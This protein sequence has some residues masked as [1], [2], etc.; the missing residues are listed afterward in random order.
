[1]EYTI[2]VIEPTVAQVHFKTNKED[3]D[4]A[5]EKAYK[6]AA[7]KLKLPG[8]RVGKAPIDLVK[9]QLG[10]SV[11]EDAI[12][13]LLIDTYNSVLEQLKPKPISLP[14]FNIVNLDKSNGV[15]FT[16]EYEFLPEIHLTKYKK[17]KAKMYELEED[18]TLIDEIL[19]TLASRNPIYLPKEFENESKNVIEEGDLVLIHLKIF[20]EN[21]NK[22]LYEKE[23]YYV[24]LSGTNSLFPEIKNHLLGKK[25]NDEFEFK[26]KMGQSKEFKKASN[27]VVHIKGKILEIKYKAIP[28]IDDEFAR[29][30]QYESLEAFKN[31]IRE[32]IL[33]QSNEYIKN[34]T[35]TE[36]IKEM[37]EREPF[38]I[39]DV[40]VRQELKT[41]LEDIGNRLFLQNVTLEH[42]ASIMGKT[43]EELEKELRE[44]IIMDL[45]IDMVL[46]KLIELEHIEATPEEISEEIKNQYGTYFSSEEKL[47]ELEKNAKVLNSVIPLIKRRKITKWIL[48]NSDIKKGERISTRKL[49]E[50]KKIKI[51]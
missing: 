40:I 33:S 46:E 10:D 28:K 30:F 43:P 23:E 9:K 49:Y 29:M 24:E 17:I 13:I 35:I 32:E 7:K 11:L 31:A 38:E 5:F 44:K 34:H 8:F 48:E 3:L 22:L 50:E 16:A 27:K 6:K 36:I 42:L 39:P 21:G 18:P 4:I 47:K 45:K 12:E 26:T 19:N 37:I 20:T 2:K 14:I 51:L 25:V 15:E 1:M 41:R